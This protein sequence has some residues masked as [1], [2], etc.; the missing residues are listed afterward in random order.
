VGGEDVQL[1]NRFLKAL[2]QAALAGT[3]EPVFPYLADDVDW[4]PRAL[5]GIDE[6]RA[7]PGL[8]VP[9]EELA[10]EFEHG[11]VTDLG[12]G[13]IEAEVR[14]LYRMKN[15]GEVAS[16]RDRRIEILIRDGKVVR[17]DM[18]IVG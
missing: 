5:S 10:I 7:H 15:T 3:L 17:Y 1:A 13:R 18:Q 11:E 2:R 6:L 4:R 12:D 14:Q 9:P 16:T 8:G